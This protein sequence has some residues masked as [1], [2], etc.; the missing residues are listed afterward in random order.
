MS[1]NRRALVGQAMHARG[2]A[3]ALGQRG[4]VDAV[5]AQRALRHHLALLIQLA[6][7]V[8]ARPGAVLA[9][10]ALVVIDQHD[11]V[12]GPLVAGAGRAHRHARRILA[13]QARF[14]EMDRLRVRKLA[15]LEGLHAVEERAGRIVVV[16]VE[17][18]ERPGAT[19][20]VPFLAARDAGMA[21]DADVEIDDEREL[22]AAHRVRSPLAAAG[23]DTRSQR[24]RVVA[25]AGRRRHRR[26]LRPRDL[27]ARR[28]RP[29][30]SA[31][32]RRTTPPGR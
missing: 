21:A 23:E 18:G 2:L 7:A 6:H 31:R 14:R 30:R 11:A 24:G 16:R 26:E 27:P 17:V 4:V 8:R 9:A 19:R 22:A 32:G 20:R 3:L 5:D 10:D 25:S 12:L 1:P 15:H 28:P 13:V 29:C